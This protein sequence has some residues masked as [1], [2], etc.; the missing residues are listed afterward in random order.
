MND[1]YFIGQSV[2]IELDPAPFDPS[3]GTSPLIK[4]EKPDGTTGQWN[5]S[6][7]GGKITYTTNSTDLDVP[8]TWKL[9]AFVIKGGERRR[10][11]MYL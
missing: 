11:N 4:Y 3:G 7:V 10:V 6:I 2:Y 9:Q 1:E 8:G 5:A